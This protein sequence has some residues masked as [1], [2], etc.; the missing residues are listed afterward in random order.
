MAEFVALEVATFMGE[1]LKGNPK[2]IQPLFSDRSIFQSPLWKEMVAQRMH[3]LSERA[4]TQYFG[5]ISERIQ[6]TSS[7]KTIQQGTQHKTL[8]HVGYIIPD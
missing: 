8:Y 2:N 3:I 7:P 5:F 1:L 6:L 4:I